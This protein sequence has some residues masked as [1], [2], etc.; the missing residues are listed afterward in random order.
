MA[1]F[2]RNPEITNK[3][4]KS[5]WQG[6]IYA[7]QNAGKS[8]LAS[9]APK[10]FFLATEHGC[11]HLSDV[12]RYMTKAGD[13]DKEKLVM[14][15]NT[16]EFFEILRFYVTQPHDYKTI[17]IDSA[18][19]AEFLFIK[20]IIKQ[21]P[22]TIVKKKEVKVECLEDVPFGALFGKVSMVWSSRFLAASRALRAKGI[23]VLL[24]CHAIPKKTLSPDGDEYPRMEIDL[25]KYGTSVNVGN[26]LSAESSWVYYIRNEAKVD[27]VKMGFGTEKTI[28]RNHSE[29]DII[30][31]TRSTSGFIA[32]QRTDGIKKIPLHY[33]LD[34]NNPAT[35]QVIFDDLED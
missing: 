9:F 32:K 35:S 14:P 5:A 29:C 13:S 30:V 10:P 17:V 3:K 8:W 21:N 23:N 4:I 12:G 15:L 11:E 25:L 34:W 2:D 31:Y 1:F 16:E 27:T 6:I 18:K 20:D 33:A 26:M 28:A 22:T 24:L 7:E 19:F